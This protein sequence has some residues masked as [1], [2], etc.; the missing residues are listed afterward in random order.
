VYQ[1]DANN[2]SPHI[3][4]EL[5]LMYTLK[6]NMTILLCPLVIVMKIRY[7]VA[8]ESFVNRTEERMNE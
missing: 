6:D 5:F 7:A 8:E 4:I 2:A 3:N 1:N